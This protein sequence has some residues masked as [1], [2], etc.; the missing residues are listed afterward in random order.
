MTSRASI[1]ITVGAIGFGVQAALLT[2]L[3]VE[4]DVPYLVATA[5]AVEGAVLHNFVWHERW[6][7]R[8]RQTAGHGVLARLL[9]FNLGTGLASIAGNVMVTGLVVESFHLPALAANVCA[10]GVTSLANFLVADRFVFRRTVP[11]ACLVAA[12]LTLPEN[13]AA[14]Q[15]RAETLEGW[16][17]HVAALE[18]S[19]RDHDADPP[20]WEPSGRAIPVPGGII[21]EWRGTVIVSGVTVEQLVHAL[22]SPGLPPPAEEILEARVLGRDGDTL[23]VYMKLTRSA[24]ITVTYDTE[25]EVTFV[26]RSAAFATSRSVATRIREEDGSDRGFLW[27]L[28]SYWRYRQ[29]GNDVVVDL[30]SVTLSRDVPA[31]VRPIVGPVIDSIARESVR[32]TLD[33]VGRFGSRLHDCGRRC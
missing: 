4:F 17:R 20:A 2:L 7:W 22:E 8:D 29:Q 23:R 25:H 28:N 21:H 10:V 1:F 11:A 14:A 16:N 33:A 19:L 31:V 12:C 5:I 13:A 26:H 6:T 24:V 3:V 18:S 30:L 15:L 9:R 27:R 32:R